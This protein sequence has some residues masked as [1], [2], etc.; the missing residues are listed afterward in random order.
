M[1][2]LFLYDWLSG[3]T[4]VEDFTFF[5]YDDVDAAF[6]KVQQVKYSQTVIFEF[7]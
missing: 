6:E 7:I 3:H 2:Q 5:N 4:N 1:G